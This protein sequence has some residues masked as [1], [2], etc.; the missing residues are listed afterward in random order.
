M[1]GQNR[2]IILANPCILIWTYSS[3][4]CFCWLFVVP[5]M[6]SSIQR[7]FRH[8]QD[9][10]FAV[11]H[12]DVQPS[13]SLFPNWNDSWK[14]PPQNVRDFSSCV[15]KPMCLF[16]LHLDSAASS[17]GMLSMCLQASADTKRERCL[18]SRVSCNNSLSSCMYSWCICSGK[19]WSVRVWLFQ[20]LWLISFASCLPPSLS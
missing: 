4:N 18:D 20:G 14:L 19:V 2:S 13:L 9:S 7:H 8:C 5:G 10:K 16:A 17:L 6:L 1:I 11:S 15:V 3:C 12:P